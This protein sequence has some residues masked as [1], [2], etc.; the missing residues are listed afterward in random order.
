MSRAIDVPSSRLLPNNTSIAGLQVTIAIGCAHNG[1][2]STS[3]VNDVIRVRL[4]D[5]MEQEAIFDVPMEDAFDGG[6]ITNSWVR[7]VLQQ[8]VSYSMQIP[9]PPPPPKVPR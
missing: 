7:C 5:D 8:Q 3:T 6:F 4:I 1:V 2:D 9:P